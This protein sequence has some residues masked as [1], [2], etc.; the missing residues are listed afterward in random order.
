MPTIDASRVGYIVGTGGSSFATSRTA[1]GS[2]VYDSPS[3]SYTNP[4]QSFYSSGRGGGTYRQSRTYIYFDTSGIHGTVTS[5]TLKIKSHSANTTSDVIVMN[6]FNAFGG[7]GNTALNVD[8]FNEV[9]AAGASEAFSADFTP[10]VASSINAIPLTAKAFLALVADDDTVLCVMN[11]TNDEQDVAPTTSPY[12][13][14]AGIAFGTTIKLEY[15]LEQFSVN[16][17]AYNASDKFNG[18]IF[19]GDVGVTQI[20]TIN[21]VSLP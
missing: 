1:N 14:G 16:G 3:I 4:I 10:W 5:A 21:G 13:V 19:S 7:D 15:A 17:V 12:A 20:D 9:N 2:N 6:G 18:T 8:D 11:Y